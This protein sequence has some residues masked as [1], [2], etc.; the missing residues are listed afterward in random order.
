MLLT[1]ARIFLAALVVV[2][3]VSIALHGVPPDTRFLVP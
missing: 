1:A 3:I 2:V